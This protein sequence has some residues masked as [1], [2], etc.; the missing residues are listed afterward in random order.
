MLVLLAAYHLGIGLVSVASQRWTASV[1][2]G[3]YGL[4]VV[5]GDARFQ[6]AMK[7]LG[8]YALA[9][10]GLLVLAAH[11]PTAN[12]PVLAA[13]LFLQAARGVSRLTFHRL[14][15][16][17]FGVDPRRNAAHA[18]LLLATAALLAWWFPRG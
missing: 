15:A 6:Y 12:R 3:M 9:L 18:F 4:S 16:D 8:L 10:G 17:A 2:H 14:L 7:M 11:D 1:A 13:L 5:G